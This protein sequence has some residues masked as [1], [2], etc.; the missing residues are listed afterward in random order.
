M[1]RTFYLVI[2]HA[3]F[4][5]EVD[6]FVLKLICRHVKPCLTWI[7]ER[8]N[9]RLLDDFFPNIALSLKL[10]SLTI[11]TEQRT[12]DLVDSVLTHLRP[13]HFNLFILLWGRRR[14]DEHIKKMIFV[15]FWITVSEL[16]FN[17]S[18]IFF[19]KNAR[20]YSSAMLLL[21]VIMLIS[22]HPESYNK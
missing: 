20:C 19:F 15:T 3:I 10:F 22:T 4:S 17:F 6:M 11:T 18:T 21:T 9:K 8:L 7:Y 2:L 12:G 13:R 5:W 1:F 16:F 14:V